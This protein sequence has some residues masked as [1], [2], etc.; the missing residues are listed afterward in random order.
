[1]GPAGAGVFVGCVTGGCVTGGSVGGCV[2][3]GVV[4]RGDGVIV[5]TVQFSCNG[6]AAQAVGSIAKPDSAAV[7]S[8]QP[9]N[10]QYRLFIA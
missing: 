5:G 6:L 9:V 10:N 2:G 8:S 3:D 7:M 4:G 1:V